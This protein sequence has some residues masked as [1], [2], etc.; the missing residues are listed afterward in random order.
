MKAVRFNNHGGIE[1]LK[2]EEVKDPEPKKDEV[3]IR[4]KACAL[5]HLDIWA[6][7]GLPN[8]TIP[9]PHI[10]GSDISGTVVSVPEGEEKIFPGMDVIISPGLSC[11]R[12]EKCSS[13]RENQCKEYKII[14]Y[15]TDGGYAELLC[16]PAYNVIE[17]P[18]G[19]NFVEAASFP[20]VFLT[21]YSMLVEKASVKPGD[22]VVVLGAG[23]GVGIASIQIAKL[24]NAKVIATAGNEEKLSKAEKLGADYVLNHYT[25]DIVSEVRKITGKRGADIVIEHVGKATWEKSLKILSTGGKLVTCGATTGHEATTDL[26]YVFS[27]EITILGNYMGSKATLLKVVELFKQGKLKPVIDGVFPLEEARKAQERMEKSMHFG[28]I[29]LEVS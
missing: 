13:G 28:K 14:G 1:V 29:V 6:R 10:P 8:V 27:R 2:L 26:R 24:F 19:L 17:K 25:Q 20:L 9:L 21:A 3:L 12:C 4:V 15:Q 23:S 5:N 11:R 18:E 22:Y 7:K 16:V